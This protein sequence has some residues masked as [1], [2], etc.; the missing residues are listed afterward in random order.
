MKSISEVTER[1]NEVDRTPLA[2][3]PIE[4]HLLLEASCVEVS[5]LTH[6]LK[7]EVEEIPS[8]LAAS[9]K[10]PPSFFQ[11]TAAEIVDK[12]Q[13]FLAEWYKLKPVVQAI[14]TNTEASEMLSD[15]QAQIQ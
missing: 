14:T 8:K 4:Q 5:K 3:F 11:A 1:F 9:A 13:K 12:N 15:L 6:Q 10:K 2:L 7:Q